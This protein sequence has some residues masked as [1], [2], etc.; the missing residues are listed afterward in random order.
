M[1]WKCF[2]H[3]I[4]I[5]THTD[6]CITDN[7]NCNCTDGTITGKG[8]VLLIFIADVIF[9]QVEVTYT[10]VNGSYNLGLVTQ[11]FAQHVVSAIQNM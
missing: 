4:K 3:G 11:G 9:K 5:Q 6:K 8:C 7:T 1:S 10:F 2:Q